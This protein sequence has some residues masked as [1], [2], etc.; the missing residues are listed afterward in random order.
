[1]RTVGRILLSGWVLLALGVALTFAWPK[2]ASRVLHPVSLYLQLIPM[3]LLVA[4]ALYGL[5][6]VYRTGIARK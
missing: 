2:L 1:M 3:I 6:R 4:T 5:A